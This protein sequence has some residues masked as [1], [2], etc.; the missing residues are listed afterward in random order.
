MI[1]LSNASCAVAVAYASV[2]ILLV[3]ATVVVIVLSL[4]HPQKN[5]RELQLR[6]RSWW[7]IVALFSL[8]IFGSLGV[9]MTVFGFISFLALKEYLSLIPTRRADRRALFWAYLSIPAQYLWIYQGWY[10]MF[11]IFI[12]LYLFLFLP[13]RMIMIGETREFLRGASTI[14]WGLM[15]TVF[16]LGHVAFLLVLPGEKNPAGGG[17]GL[18]L[19]LVALTEI[20]DISQYIWGKLLGR[21]KVAPKVSPNKTWAGFL[22]GVFTV[23]LLAILIAPYLTPLSVIH[24]VYAGLIISLGGFVGDITISALKRDIGVKDTGS[25][26]PGHGGILDRVDSLSYSAPLFFHFLY[27]IYY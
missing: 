15:I 5:H 6:V 17:P 21:A 13:V 12:P 24:S 1:S 7:V 3:L 23:T 8:T 9:A 20:N 26:L 22:G 18:V 19:F 14:H 27:F 16:C 25:L 4:V 10:G 11:V 2:L